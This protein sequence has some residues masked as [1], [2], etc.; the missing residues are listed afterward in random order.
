MSGSLRTVTLMLAIASTAN[1][2]NWFMKPSLPGLALT[3]YHA[4]TNLSANES[5]AS[6]IPWR[7]AADRIGDAAVRPLERVDALHLLVAE[8][9]VEHGN[10]LGQASGVR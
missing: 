5:K 2:P 9:E 3:R 10:V 8:R 4:R 1:K 6:H 7:Y